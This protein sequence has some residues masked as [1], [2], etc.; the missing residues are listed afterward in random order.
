[1]KY[2]H[3]EE[4]NN[5]RH[6]LVDVGTDECDT[7]VLYTRLPEDDRK[8]SNGGDYYAGYVCTLLPDGHWYC[9]KNT[10]IHSDFQSQGWCELPLFISDDLMNEVIVAVIDRLNDKPSHNGGV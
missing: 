8:S 10:M 3:V 1:M 9:R 2:L 7:V 6:L 5:I 4:I